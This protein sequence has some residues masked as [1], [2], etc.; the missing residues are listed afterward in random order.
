MSMGKLR[1]VPEPVVQ[2][3]YIFLD[4]SYSESVACVATEQSFTR[5]V[6]EGCS[7]QSQT[8]IRGADYTL[9]NC[10]SGGWNNESLPRSGAVCCPC[11]SLPE[12]SASGTTSR[13]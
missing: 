8:S 4:N 5:R 1:R 9:G 11:R 6:S 2:N 10:K 13:S 7:C 12:Q 3:H